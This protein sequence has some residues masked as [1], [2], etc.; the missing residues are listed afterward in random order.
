MTKAN[1]LGINFSANPVSRKAVQAAIKA[2][3]DKIDEQRAEQYADDLQRGQQVQDAGRKRLAE[4]KKAVN[5]FKIHF[6]PFANELLFAH[7]LQ[8][9]KERGPEISDIGN[10][11]RLAM[12]PQLR[13]GQL[14]YEFFQRADAAGQCDER[15]SPFKHQH[16]PFVHII[17]DDQFIDVFQ[18]FLFFRQKRR[19]N[20][21]YRAASS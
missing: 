6:K 12:L 14:L 9:R 4:L 10:D 5:D 3:Q 8:K 17:N 20:A 2:R 15:V 19:N 13:P 18:H 11:N 1:K 16:F 7:M 21:G